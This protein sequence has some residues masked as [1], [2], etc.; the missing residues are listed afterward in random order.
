MIPLSRTVIY[1]IAAALILGAFLVNYGGIIVSSRVQLTVITAIVGLLLVTVAFS[2]PRIAPANFSPFFP[3]GLLTI[4]VAAALI[5]WSYL[6]YENVSNVAEEFKNPKRDF[7]RNIVLSVVVISLL[8]FSVA[9]AAVGT[10]AYVSGGSV[11]PFAAM[12]S[13][14]LGV[15]GALGTV[16]AYTTGISRV[17]YATAK[18]GGFPRVLDRIDGRTGVP[19]R[20]LLLLAALSLVTLALSFI[21][22]LDLESALL[23]PSGAAIFV[24][25]IGS[26]SG[27][28]LLRDKGAKRMFPWISLIISL[29]MLPFV[30]I[31]LLVSFAF[32]LMGLIYKRQ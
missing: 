16:N 8:Y 7:H 20:A 19:H 4:G 2:A 18:Q 22:N 6:G 23:I 10:R 13:N 21:L 32:A 24:Y 5:F 3:N 9:A 26:A 27:I 30:G 29:L 31:F 28:R 15:Y 11:A 14:A 25:I 17:I 12:L 1:L